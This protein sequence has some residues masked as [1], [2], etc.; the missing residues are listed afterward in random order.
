VRECSLFWSSLVLVV[1]FL[2]FPK[3][4]T[5]LPDFSSFLAR[6]LRL[7]IVVFPQGMWGSLGSPTRAIV[8]LP[9]NRRAE[10]PTAVG[11]S[12]VLS[13]S[14]HSPRSSQ[15]TTPGSVHGRT[16]EPLVGTPYPPP[17]AANKICR[18]LPC[19]YTVARSVVFV[20]SK[21]PHMFSQNSST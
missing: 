7:T 6:S 16:R 20:K 9:L 1:F 5:F 10:S 18:L 12:G 8:A 4:G 19:S 3:V 17:K 14:I 21:F 13:P 11:H 15:W 2:T